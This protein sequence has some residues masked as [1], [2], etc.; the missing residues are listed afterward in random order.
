METT[1]TNDN[2]IEFLD[3]DHLSHENR[4]LRKMLKEK[5]QEILKLKYENEL[6]RSVR[7]VNERH[8]PPYGN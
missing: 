1:I 5:D 4:L 3:S 7:I 8:S 2:S 6:L